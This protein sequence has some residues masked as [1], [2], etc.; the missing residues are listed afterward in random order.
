MNTSGTNWKY[1]KQLQKNLPNELGWGC[2]PDWKDS[3]YTTH[4]K[5]HGTLAVNVAVYCETPVSDTYSTLSPD[6]LTIRV[7]NLVG[8]GFDVP[9]QPDHQA[10]AQENV[11]PDKKAAK[12]WLQPHVTSQLQKVEAVLNWAHTSGPPIRYMHLPAVGCGHF[13]GNMPIRDVWDDLSKEAVLKWK[14][15]W[16]S[17]VYAVVHV[18][19]RSLPCAL[20]L[21]G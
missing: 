1:F 8:L 5:T 6:F 7:L 9:E 16:P 20:D 13:A 2:P 17:L 15:A 21:W 19:F 12:E 10:F 3:Y 14:T 11:K 18:F 4:Y